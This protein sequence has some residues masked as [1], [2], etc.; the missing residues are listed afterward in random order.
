MKKLSLLAAIC[1]ALT[2]TSAPLRISAPWV[3]A[4][5]ELTALFGGDPDITIATGKDGDGNYSVTLLV[6]DADKADALS[7]LLEPEIDFGNVKLFVVVKSAN[8]PVTP[9][10]LVLR[11][12]TGNPAVKTFAS[13]EHGDLYGTFD[14]V[15]FRKEVVQFYNDQLDDPNGLLSTLYA[16]IA[17]KFVKPIPGVYFSTNAN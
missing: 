17:R 1:A 7:S 13:A 4:T 9:A 8:E 14:Y 10:E 5:K 15:M 16:D 12:F 2:A 11:A 6:N 3:T